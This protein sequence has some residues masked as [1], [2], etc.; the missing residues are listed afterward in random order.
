MNAKLIQNLTTLLEDETFIES[1]MRA[2]TQSQSA[3]SQQDDGSD[4]EEGEE[5]LDVSQEEDEERLAQAEKIFAKE[6]FDSEVEEFMDQL[7]EDEMGNKDLKMPSDLEDEEEYGDEDRLA[8]SEE[9]EDESDEGIFG[10]ADDVDKDLAFPEDEASEK[11]A[12]ANADEELENVFANAREN[13]EMDLVDQLRKKAQSSDFVNREAVAKIEQLEDDMM[14]PKSWA[15][16]GE[17]LAK[18]RPKDSLLNVHLDF[19]AA[20]KLP[21]VI[22]KETTNAIEA[23]IKQRIADELFD[24]PVLKNDNKR[25]KL[26]EAA[27]MDFNKS[28]KGLGDIYAD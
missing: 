14:N 4:Q 28:T 13:R 6:E 11:E 19:N 2:E 25:K 17:V 3:A 12:G 5:E 8:G 22:T 24:D 20:T 23:L 26:N 21:P 9:G 16:T 7:E 1:V 27:E 15:L 18:E 10:N